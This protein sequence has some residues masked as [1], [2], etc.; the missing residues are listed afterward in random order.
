MA[1]GTVLFATGV[2]IGAAVGAS[3]ALLYAPMSG[4]D[5]RRNL[6][7]TASRFGQRAREMYDGAAEAASDLAAGGAELVDQFKDAADRTRSSAN[8]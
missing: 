3:V 1:N 7:G 2:A 5:T 8:A 6:R 4:E